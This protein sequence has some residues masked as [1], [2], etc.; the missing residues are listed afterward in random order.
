MS[1][2]SGLEFYFKE[3]KE[4]VQVMTGLAR[5]LLTREAV[6]ALSQFERTVGLLGEQHTDRPFDLEVGPVR[7][8]SSAGEYEN[9]DRKGKEIFAELS[10]KWRVIPIGASG[11]KRPRPRFRLVGLASTCISIRDDSNQILARWHMDISDHRSPGCYFHVQVSQDRDE[12]PFPSSLPIPRFPNF[13]VTPMAALDFILGELFQDRWLKR[14]SRGVHE[15]Q[16]WRSIQ[17]KRWQH[18]LCWHLEHLRETAET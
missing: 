12:T 18:L 15:A 5:P 2:V 8:C 14:T 17:K 4:E 1:D 13:L 6:G 11:R 16:R 9:V 3:F 10:S 7:T